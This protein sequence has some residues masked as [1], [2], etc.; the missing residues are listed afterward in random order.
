MTQIDAGLFL[1]A[2]LV[3]T[4]SYRNPRGLLWIGAA[5]LSYINASFAWRLHLPYAEVITGIG[6]AAVCLAIYFFGKY[7]WELV[8]WRLFQTSVAVSIFYLAGNIGIFAHISHDVYSSMLEAINWL[9][10]LMLGGMAILK[11]I[12]VD[13]DVGAYHSWRPLHRLGATLQRKRTQPP[14]SKV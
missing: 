9:L 11:W 2:V 14:F 1:G 13:D 8:I 4:L 3:A 5:A 10:L 7:R 6:D 12:G